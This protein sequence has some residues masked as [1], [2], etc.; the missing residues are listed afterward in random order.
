MVKKADEGKGEIE[1]RKSDEKRREKFLRVRLTNE[2]HETIHKAAERAGIILS[3]WVVERLMLVAKKEL[4]EPKG[5][6]R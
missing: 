4:A 1:R 5:Q 6:K 2:Q 3:S